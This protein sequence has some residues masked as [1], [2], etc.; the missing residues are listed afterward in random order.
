MKVTVEPIKLGSSYLIDESSFTAVT[1]GI[2]ELVN[3]GSITDG[4]FANSEHFGKF[5]YVF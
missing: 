1:F 3:I 5:H 2:A 4:V